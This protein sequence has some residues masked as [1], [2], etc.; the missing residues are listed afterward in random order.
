MKKTFFNS[1]I[2]AAIV[3]SGSMAVVSCADYDEDIRAIQVQ[4]DEQ[5]KLTDALKNQVNG[6]E[7]QIKA[8]QDALAAMKSCQCGDIDAKIADKINNALSGLNY[9]TPEDVA[10]A[11][12]DALAGIQTG[13][14]EAEVQALIEAYHNAHPSCKCGDLEELIKKYLAD[15]PG[16]SEGDVTLIIEQ[17]MKDHPTN[18]L[19]EG[20]V[21]AIIETYINNLQHFTKEEILSMINTAITQAL[22]NYECQC[23]NGLTADEVS[24]IA[25]SV[26]DQYMKDHPYTL[27][28]EA[29]QNIVNTTIQNS[30]VINNLSSSITLLQNTVTN[31]QNDLE[32]LKNNVY[33][34]EEVTIVINTLIQ[35]AIDALDLPAQS[36][37]D[38]QKSEVEALI[39][40]AIDEYAKNHPDCA[41]GFDQKALDE[42]INGLDERITAL[43][44]AGH[45]TN[46]QLE[47]AIKG[48]K[49]YADQLL[50]NANLEDYVKNSVFVAEIT[51]IDNTITELT[52]KVGNAL[53]KANANEQAIQDLN[54]VVENLNN[55]Y[56]ELSEK[57]EE[58][59]NKAIAAYNRANNNYYEI[60]T[61]KKLYNELLGKL[62]NGDC[63]PENYDE[64]VESLKQLEETVKTLASKSDVEDLLKNYYT[65]EEV[66]NL[67]KD[68]ATRDEVTTAVE[69]AKAAA[70]QLFN[71]AK[72]Y[73][74]E[75]AATAAAQALS[76]AKDYTDTKIGELEEAYKEADRLLRID[77]NTLSEKVNAFDEK[78]KT[79]EDELAE[80][81]KVTNYV[82]KLIT[83]IELQG[84]HN[85]AFGYYS[86]PVGVASNMLIAYF[87]KNEHDTYFPAIDDY[88]LVYSDEA[89]W[90]TEADEKRLN[91]K[92]GELF[93]SGGTTITNKEGYA[94][95]GKLYMTV[96]PSSVDFSGTKFKLVNSIGEESPVTLDNLR[97]STDVLKF[98][99]TRATVD[100]NSNQGFYE[101]MAKVPVANLNAAEFETKEFTDYLQ[102]VAQEQVHANLSNVAQAIYNQFNGKLDAYAIQATWK[103]EL[104][105][106]TTTSRYDIAA[107]AV[108]PL[109][110]NFFY[111]YSLKLPT[112]TPLTEIKLSDYIDLSKF[113][114]ELGDLVNSV[115]DVKIT[116]DFSN[117][118]VHED[119]SVWSDITVKEANK[120]YVKK[121]IM[122]VSATGVYT[123]PVTGK[124]TTF[125]NY[126]KSMAQFVATL[127]NDRADAWSAQL[128]QEFYTQ[129]G[130]ITDNIDKIMDSVNGQLQGAI[131]D[132]LAGVEH[133]LNSS[134]GGANELLND[135]N[136]ILN[137]LNLYL[138]N[139]NLRLQ[140]HLLFRG[141]D[142][143]YHPMS[144]AKGMP[145]HLTGEGAL[146]FGLT[147]YTGEFLTPA[148][149]KYVAVTNV[150]KDGQDADSSEELM[151]ALKKANSAPYFDEIIDGDRW[152]VAFM[153]DA[154]LE[155]ATYEIVYSALD[156]HGKI[157]QRK[158]Y[159]K[160]N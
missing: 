9:A 157:S 82:A 49:D 1:M 38:G 78:F 61:L 160:V 152:A 15:N 16:L 22:A 30:E 57:Y 155:G 140:A 60:Q 147:G 104:G 145:N 93:I 7:G 53:D 138:D 90:I 95:A 21:K 34:K 59:Y 110:Y 125:E 32:A 142:G 134:L 10:K 108:K 97:P 139:P 113:K 70:K 28:V 40:A 153:P 4:V 12:E 154:S 62:C 18:S 149:K 141:T 109:S 88:D 37:S 130:K 96:N 76:D 156:Y 151:S 146:D 77:L 31:I 5:T 25:A 102:V 132:V 116:V 69:G 128:Y 47:D 79:I 101:A 65:K 8:L 135:L 122:I 127:I 33:T 100:G 44:N 20:D 29:V 129:L 103:D 58:I 36:L 98:G 144:T 23:H 45:V 87:G 6:L 136:V 27:D 86:L 83:S 119:G 66:D 115:K 67:I 71:D 52:T 41:C 91:T 121:S 137:K 143:F 85:P 114:I 75:V 17:Y 117:L 2:F 112:L 55:L 68:F 11:I 92:R 118:S 48:A 148:Y 131:N 43:E 126:Q 84:T 123:D 63:K 35:Q 89:N 24:A 13:L 51:R 107:T 26:I 14:T 80:I 19:T 150:Y 120:E 94:D 106:H 133:K 74:D 99:H 72:D 81:K 39:S 54:Q 56:I 50:K 42:I 46:K 159:V 158:F 105:E 124:T 111:G 3:L 73:A 64:M